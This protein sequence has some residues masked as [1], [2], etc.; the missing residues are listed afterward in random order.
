M[1]PIIVILLLFSYLL[2]ATTHL[3]GVNKAAIS[4]V[5]AAIG[6][7]VYISWGSDFVMDLHSVA[8]S[9]YLGENV[10]TSD[11]VKNFIYDNVFLKYVGKAAAIVMYLLATMSIIEILNTNGCFDFINEWIRTRNTN[12][13][14]LSW[15]LFVEVAS[16]L[17][18]IL[19]AFCCGPMKPLLLLTFLAIWLSLHWWL[20]LCQRS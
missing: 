9:E 8:Y 10:A 3:I 2:I 11:T 18:V 19:R 1:T 5:L 13:L 16:L 6:W 7:V 17:L 15:L 4:I 20:G 12:R 14:L